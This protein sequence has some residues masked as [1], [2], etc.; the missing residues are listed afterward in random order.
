MLLGAH[1]GISG[2]IELAPIEARKIGCDVMQIFSKNQQ[3][4]SA[5]PLK[6][7]AVAAFRANVKAQKIQA[8]GVHTSY[9]INLGSPQPGLQERSLAAFRDEI[10]RAEA[11]GVDFLIFHPG[12][13]TGSGEVAGLASIGSGVRRALEETPGRK[14]RV[15]FETAAGQGSTLGCTFEQLGHLLD[16]VDHPDRTG[17]CVDTCHIF[18]SGYDFRTEKGYKAMIEK[19][20]SAI[21][22]KRVFAFH[23]NDAL[24]ELGSRVDRHANI[25]E[26]N[27]GL[28]GFRF[29][30]NDKRFSSTAG[31][32]ETPLKGDK[33][34]PYA[35]YEK[36][37]KTLRSL[38]KKG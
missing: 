29:L 7:E 1:I 32:L 6:P 38:V 34:R 23:M 4:W 28:S 18:A 22:S 25:G 27:I 30:V 5:N 2:G 13:H 16:T 14:V 17:V 12:A 19:L 37:L 9:L 8:V 3:Q 15:L 20:E 35:A 36:D 33:A 10:E 31:F 21:G 11:L 24:S 26:G